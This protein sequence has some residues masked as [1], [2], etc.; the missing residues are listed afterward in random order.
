MPL[1]SVP[2]N[3]LPTEWPYELVSD[4]SKD[5]KTA[6]WAD[7]H[8]VSWG[9]EYASV[10]IGDSA[11]GGALSPDERFIAITTDQF[12]K[13][14]NTK[15]LNLLKTL[16][17][18]LNLS[19]K[20]VEWGPTS[21]SRP[22]L[23]CSFKNRESQQSAIWSPSEGGLAFGDKSPTAI[24][25]GERF[26]LSSKSFSASGKSFLLY[27]K[28]TDEA[29]VVH[30]HVDV[31]D[32]T[33]FSRRLRIHNAHLG[34]KSRVSFAEFVA[35][36][37]LILT[38]SWDQTV[39]LWDADTGSLAHTFGP[40]GAQNWVAGLNSTGT[41]VVCGGGTKLFIWDTETGL[42]LQTLSTGYEGWVRSLA[43]SPDGTRLLYGSVGGCLKMYNMASGI[44]EQTW[45]LSLTK[46]RTP[47]TTEVRGL[48][49]LEGGG[50]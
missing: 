44:V 24:F 9:A 29:A 26:G 19:A 1:L 17:A 22:Q 14:Y 15:H 32:T 30:H 27:C 45:R 41:R 31:M 12:I 47:S 18:L 8:P 16:H 3:P 36:D 50:R 28:E 40:T 7:G 23:L 49:W 6:Q 10:T 39:K 46:P 48:R 4:F 35:D 20:N 42:L 21:S 37:R 33:N 5:G 38:C 43:L 2:V 11:K 34:F 13:I 25:E